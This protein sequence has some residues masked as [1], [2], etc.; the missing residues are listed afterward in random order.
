MKFPRSLCLPVVVLALAV[1]AASARAQDDT[2][3]VQE[4]LR[5]RSLYFGNVD[6]RDS[7]ELQEATRRYQS[8]KGFP[9]TGKPD[10]ETLRSLGLVPRSPNEPPPP[11]LNWPAEPVLQSDERID[12][13]EIAESLSAE[14]GIAPA[15]VVSQAE[16]K[17]G[18]LSTKR[19][20]TSATA[21]GT[22]AR[23]GAGTAAA[24]AVDPRQKP[25]DSPYLTPQ[26]L[27]RFASDYFSA[28][29]SNDIKRQLRFYGDK[30]DYFRN[31]AIDRRI[32]E[33]ALR[34]YHARWPRRRYQMGP[35]VSYSRITPRGEIVMVFPINFTLSD[36]T[37]T[38]RGAT[39]NRLVISAATVDPRITSISEQRI[40]R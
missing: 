33:Q 21:A 17:R 24:P 14:T 13:V 37:R 2:R 38:V 26:E 25:K 40:R 7:A 30:I 9:A 16:A 6:G 27:A 3:S 39:N 20:A 31:G 36:G 8:R 4:E 1:S 10:R 29:G 19:R 34:R 23:P 12:T 35:A 28:M 18:G 32:V 5:R 15:S 22:G 11:E